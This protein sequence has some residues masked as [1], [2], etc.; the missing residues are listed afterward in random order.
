[1][2]MEQNSTFARTQIDVAAVHAVAHQL[3][4]ATELI[5]DAAR[6]HLAKLAFDGATAGREYVGRGDALRTA[7]HQLTG[8]LAQWSRASVEIATA[9]RASAGRYVDAELSAAARIG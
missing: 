3:D 4:S 1:M 7:L 8:E 5:E 6:N 9:L 2:G